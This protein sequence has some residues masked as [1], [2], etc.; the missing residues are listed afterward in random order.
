[1]IPSEKNDKM[2]KNGVVHLLP[3]QVFFQ[4]GSAEIAPLYLSGD[5]LW[6]FRNELDLP[7][8]LVRRSRPLDISLEILD[9]RFGGF[10]TLVQ[11]DK[12]LHD[13]PP[14][15]VRGADDRCFHDRRVLDQGALHFERP[16]PV[17]EL[18]IT[19]S[20]RPTNQK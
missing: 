9:E 13:Q 16:D 18:L 6:E 1:M 2:E 20:S 12:C 15:P 17:P 5:G 3:V 4:F 14:D 11:D 10:V 19:S 8:V 7:R